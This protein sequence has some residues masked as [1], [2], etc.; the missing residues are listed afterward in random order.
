MKSAGSVA[1][2]KLP[3]TAEEWAAKLGKSVA[4][5]NGYR[6]GGRKP[7]AAV[8]DQIHELGGPAPPWWDQP[9]AATS[10]RRIPRDFGEQASPEAT[11][12][13]ADK[14]QGIASALLDEIDSDPD[15]GA[16]IR[17]A[18]KAGSLI[19]QLGKITG[20]AISNERQILASPAWARVEEAIETALHPW[21][22]AMRAVAAELATMRN[23]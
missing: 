19:A 11:R 7:P 2:A 1:F 21:P 23:Q 10:P 20:I 14:L 12:Q 17:N 16:R 5:V 9:P 18:E 13:L 4:A 6:R 3:G 8:R 15:L 22:D